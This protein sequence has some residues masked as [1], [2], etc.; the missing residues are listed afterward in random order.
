[1]SQRRLDHFVFIF[2]C[3]DTFA[4]TLV[5]AMTRESRSIPNG[6][7]IHHLPIVRTL[8]LKTES[9]SSSEIKIVGKRAMVSI[10]K[11]KVLRGRKGMVP[12]RYLP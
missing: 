1:M 4:K 9:Q 11:E 10:I 6:E 2:S 7:V 8:L 12:M 3:D 5:W